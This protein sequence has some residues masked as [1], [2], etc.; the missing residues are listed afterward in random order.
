[1]SEVKPYSFYQD[2]IKYMYIMAKDY[3]GVLFS[4]IF[5]TNFIS[6]KQYLGLLNKSLQFLFIFNVKE[7]FVNIWHKQN[8]I[9][10][11]QTIQLVAS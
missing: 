2:K 4:K 6:N 7:C 8:F 5:I 11:L 3:T 9:R 10:Q 1:M